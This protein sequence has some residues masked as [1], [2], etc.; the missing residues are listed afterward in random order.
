MKN[1]FIYIFIIFSLYLTSLILLSWPIS[2]LS[3]SKSGVFGDSFGALN[4]LFTGLGFAGLLATLKQQQHQISKQDSHEKKQ[5]RRLAS[6]RFEARF[7]ILLDLLSKNIEKIKV[8]GS[9]CIEYTGVNA[10]KKIN[11]SIG[12]SLSNGKSLGSIDILSEAELTL[13]DHA[14]IANIR[15]SYIQQ[16]RYLDTL[17]C[18][19]SFIDHEC[20]A[21]SKEFYLRLLETQITSVEYKYLFYSLFTLPEESQLKNFLLNNQNFLN[22]IASS[23]NSKV[24]RKIIERRMGAVLPATQRLRYPILISKQDLKHAKHLISKNKI[25]P[26]PHNN[27]CETQEASEIL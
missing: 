26:E 8:S 14:Y 13:Y 12:L 11:E 7:F 4:A 10:I 16:S 27:S 15:K 22:S 5:E 6:D 3:I 23:V 17:E 24:K 25:N 18:I 1:P 20:P 2:E 9:D 19:T 21:S